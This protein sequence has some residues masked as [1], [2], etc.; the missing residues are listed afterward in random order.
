[1]PDPKAQKNFTDPESRIMKS[2]DGF[3]QAYNAQIAVDSTVWAV[4]NLCGTLRS[5][6]LFMACFSSGSLRSV[7][8]RLPLTSTRGPDFPPSCD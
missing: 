1:M 2:K 6:D 7:P 3:V 4:T 5:A 8:I